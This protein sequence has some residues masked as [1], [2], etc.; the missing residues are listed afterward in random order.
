MDDT[1]VWMWAGIHHGTSVEVRGQ[2]PRISS[3]L[4]PR[5]VGIE[6]RLSG[7]RGKLSY[8]LSH[9]ARPV[10]FNQQI[11]SVLQTRT[12]YIFVVCAFICVCVYI[13]I[14]IIF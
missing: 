6:L 13:Y 1:C 11:N 5:A 2:L 9:L 8:P 7:L 3:L 10:V 12:K 14:N 4:P